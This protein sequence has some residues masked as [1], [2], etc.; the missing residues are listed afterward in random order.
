MLHSMRLDVPKFNGAGPES[1]IFFITEHFALLNTSDDQRLKVVGF[2]LEGVAAEW[3]WWMTRNGLITDWD[4]FVESVKSLEDYQR[5]FE[6]LMNRV[7]DIPDSL[8]ISFYILGLKHNLQHEFLVS[9]PTT[10]GDAK[11]ASPKI[12]G[13]LNDDEDIGVDEVSSATDGV[14]D[15]GN[16]ESMEVYSKF[17]EF[18]KNK[19]IVKEVVSG[20]EALGVGKDDDS[21]NATMDG[22]DDAVES[23]DISILNSL[24]GYGSSYSS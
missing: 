18:S 6:K 12:R 20:G 5:E 22:G 3:F 15:M 19:K 10:L 21:S 11:L 2:N 17:G 8:L 9:R 4:R 13:S 14:F 23:E 7:T 24:I 1:C 16:V